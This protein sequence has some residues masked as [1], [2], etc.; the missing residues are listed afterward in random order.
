M[1]NNVLNWAFRQP[2]PSSQR[3]VLVVLANYA[4]SDGSGARP[5][6]KKISSMTGLSRTT[7]HEA[8]KRLEAGGYIRAEAYRHGGH[9]RATV[10]QC[11]LF[12][13]T[14]PEPLNGSGTEP[15]GGKKGST[16][17]RLN[18][19]DTEH[20]TENGPV[21]EP[22]NGSNGEQNGSNGEQNGTGSE[23]QPLEP[24]NHQC[25]TCKSPLKDQRADRQSTKVPTWVCINPSCHGGRNG[26]P[27]ATWQDLPPR[28]SDPLT[29]ARTLARNRAKIVDL[30]VA[31][32]RVELA[33]QFGNDRRLIAAGLEAFH[34]AR[35]GVAV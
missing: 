27:W 26:K 34:E 8:L 22:K 33:Q 30:E 1:A 24:E 25:P 14:N 29:Q 6:L 7:I 4:H 35:S 19:T 16:T 10:W 11:M 9:G 17:E 21:T 32:I 20:E 28:V 12:N 31:D 2:V 15:F 3:F 23:P 13:S 5:P 18:G